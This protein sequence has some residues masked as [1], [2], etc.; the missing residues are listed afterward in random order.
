MNIR[1][2][3]VFAVS[4]LALAGA[5]LAAAVPA[6][7]I[8]QVP[9]PTAGVNVYSDLWSNPKDTCFAGTP[10]TVMVSIPNTYAA[11]SKVN[12]YTITFVDNGQS[13]SAVRAAGCS[14]RCQA[15]GA[16]SVWVV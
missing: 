5:G 3:A 8:A 12:N 10:G 6:N 7:A 9:C 16:R 14:Y 1:R 15:A 2:K 11:Y 4:T 13:W